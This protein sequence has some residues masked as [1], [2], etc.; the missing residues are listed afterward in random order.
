MDFVLGLSAHRSGR[1]RKPLS[2]G[3]A[4]A[5]MRDSVSLDAGRYRADDEIR[6]ESRE[7]VIRIISRRLPPDRTLVPERHCRESA[8]QG[9]E[10]GFFQNYRSAMGT[11]EVEPLRTGAKRSSAKPMGWAANATPSNLRWEVRSSQ[12]WSIAERR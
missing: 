7:R 5:L 2:S 12:R 11:K 9:H 6:C 1:L 3:N 8:E 10:S 4:S